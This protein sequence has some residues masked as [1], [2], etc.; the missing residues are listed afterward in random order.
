M[1]YGVNNN[2]MSRIVPT[3][4]YSACSLFS[5]KKTPISSNGATNAAVYLPIRQAQLSIS[6]NFLAHNVRAVLPE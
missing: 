6:F 3:R 4:M 1:V 5:L 2:H